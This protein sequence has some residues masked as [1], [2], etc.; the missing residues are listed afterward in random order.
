[1]KRLFFI[2]LFFFSTDSFASYQFIQYSQDC[3]F[4][5]EQ[6]NSIFSARFDTE[7]QGVNFFNSIPFEDFNCHPEN[8]V[9]RIYNPSSSNLFSAQFGQYRYTKMFKMYLKFTEDPPSDCTLDECKSDAEQQCESEGLT[10]DQSSY[11]YRGPED[12][13]YQCE[14]IT[15]EEQPIKSNEQCETHSYN[16]CNN[17]GSIQSYTFV[18][19]GDSTFDCNYTCGDGTTGDKFGSNA[20]SND[21]I[22]DQNDPNDFSDCDKPEDDPNSINGSYT[23]DESNS[24]EYTAD[25]TNQSDGTGTDNL[26]NVQGDVLI[27]EIVKLKNENAVQTIKTKNAVVSAVEGVNSNNKLDEVITAINNSGGGG[28]S[29]DLSSVTSAL[30]GIKNSIGSTSLTRIKAPTDS[31]ISFWVSDYPD[32]A[33]SVWDDTKASFNNTEYV[34]FLSTFNP[35][36]A[37]G[38]P[39]DMQLCFNLGAMG[40]YGCH[41]IPVDSSIWSA[42]RIFI[43]VTAGFLCRRI[44]FGG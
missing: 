40:N 24:I 25:G 42:I 20:N 38:T 17:R 18:D 13:D 36:L 22:C 2:F 8:F 23:P 34:Q 15:P 30:D 9:Q 37:A 14:T 4:T 1:M 6:N 5:E 41:A 19:N 31:V 11:F 29:T 3:G 7:Q 33:R 26:T 32:G 16:Q 12:Y 10:L 35:N 27:N 44:I 43:L 28:E 21:G 39:L